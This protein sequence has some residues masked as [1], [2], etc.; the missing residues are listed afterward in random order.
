MGGGISNTNKRENA[1]ENDGIEKRHW[2]FD[3]GEPNFITSTVNSANKVYTEGMSDPLAARRPPDPVENK[4]PRSKLTLVKGNPENPVSGSASAGILDKG[5]GNNNSTN[6]M[7]K[8]RNDS[9]AVQGNY[10]SPV[11][12]SASAGIL[13]KGAGN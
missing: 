2:R 13:G 8:M 4:S 7:R 9:V 12:G 5:A 1:Q 10:D 11:S 6:S 3:E